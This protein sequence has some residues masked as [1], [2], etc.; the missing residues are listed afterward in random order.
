MAQ[1]K[2]KVVAWEPLRDFARE[3]FIRAGMPP[4]DAATEAEVILWANL[5]GVDS[6]GIQLLPWYV[7]AVDIGHMKVKPNIQIVKETPATLFIDADHAFGAVVTTYAMNEVMA[8]AKK[9]G[10]GW[11]FI[12]KTNHQGAMGYYPCMAAKNDMAGLAWVCGN[13]ST[14]P[15]GSKFP[16]IANNPIAISV[17]ARRHR[18][19]VLDMAMSI[20]AGAK[21]LLAKD[22]GIPIPEGWAMDKDGNPT[23]DPW[24]ASILLPIGG[25]KGSG[26][27]IMLEC[28]GSVMV[29][30]PKVEPVV[31]MKEPP[32]GM[33]SMIGNPDRIR[34]HIQNSVMVAIDISTFTDVDKYK[35]TI[36]SMIDGLKGLPKAEG[37]SEIL[38]PGEPEWRTYDERTK[39]GIPLP[40]KTAANLRKVGERFGIKLPP[41][42]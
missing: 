8:K 11:A 42:L 22:K 10:I 7:E 27:S 26:L 28:L 19:L 20:A 23:T 3:I 40:E 17:P 12:R 31:T 1:A 13:T 5:R 16:G 32:F 21:L 9:V 30:F 2:T 24:Q 37:F 35:D 34:Q 14:A 41:G 4:Q 38:V 39:N 18:P 15:F 6:H 33:G 29:D 36:D 25:A